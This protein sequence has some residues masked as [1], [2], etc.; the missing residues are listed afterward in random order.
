M[1]EVVK[2]PRN[3][4]E[5]SFDMRLFFIFHVCMM[6]LMFSRFALRV[7]I[8]LEI[9]VVSLLAIVAVVLSIQN[10]RKHH[11]HWPGTK[12]VNIVGAVLVVAFGLY[13]MGAALPGTTIFN[14]N[15]FPWL[16]AG[17]GMVTFGVLSAMRVVYQSEAEFQRHC[18]EN[19]RTEPAPLPEASTVGREIGWKKAVII[20]FGVYGLAVWILGVGFFWKFNS[21]FAHG[22]P[23]PTA[24]QTEK[25]S[26][27]SQVVYITPQEKKLVKRLELALDLGVPSLF[28]IGALLHFGAKIRLFPKE[29]PD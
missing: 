25:L 24:T 28:A 17:A 12:W 6:A 8:I 29:Q 5:L 16:A 19:R 1:N 22:S 10:R 15:L 9:C 26:N 11:W 21:A 13:F 7:G 20:V 3:W 27:H 14:P 18:G 23:T 4:K 2:Q